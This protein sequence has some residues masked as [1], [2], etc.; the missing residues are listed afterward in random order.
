MGELLGENTVKQIIPDGQKLARMVGTG[1]TGL[2][3]LY[4]VNRTD[5]D[6]VNIE[7]K[8][9]SDVKKS[10]SSALGNTADGLQGSQTWIAGSGRIE[11]AVGIESAPSVRRSVEAG[12]VESWVVRTYADGSTE[13]QVLDVL[14][15]PKDIDTSKIL[16]TIK[17]L[18]GARP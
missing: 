3:D 6:Y 7:Y 1:E 18:S 17:N 4:K 15:K 2:D 8:F 11:K 12:R 10:G 16:S 13:V 5:V 9:L 14:G